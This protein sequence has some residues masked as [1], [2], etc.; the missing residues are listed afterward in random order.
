M[1]KKKKKESIKPQWLDYIGIRAV[2]GGAI[3]PL[4]WRVQGTGC[5]VP[6]RA[7]WWWEIL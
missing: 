1:A 6:V 4:D 2:R 7:G 5:G 3:Q